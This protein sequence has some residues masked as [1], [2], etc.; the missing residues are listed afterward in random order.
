VLVDILEMKA[1]FGI[2]ETEIY[3][4]YFI[5]VISNSSE[6]YFFSA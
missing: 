2:E 4:F 3:H 6:E 1:E 5:V